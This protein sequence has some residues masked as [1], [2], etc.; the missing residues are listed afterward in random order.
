VLYFLS[1][2]FREG[3]SLCARIAAAGIPIPGLRDGGFG[4]KVDLSDP[5]WRDFRASAPLLAGVLAAFVA[6][7]RAVQARAPERRVVFYLAAGLVFN[8]A[9]H[10]A[11][12]AYVVA[13]CGASYALAHA[14]AG[15]P[16]G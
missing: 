5:Q 13:L 9:L 2:L 11:C 14:L 3:R 12:S 15:R 1:V 16:Y 6:A 4:T 10:G 7:S 8:F